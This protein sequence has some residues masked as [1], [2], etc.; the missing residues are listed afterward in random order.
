MPLRPY[1]QEQIFLLP[2]SLSEW[3][4]Q[5]H[6]ARVFSEI[7]DRID[8]HPFR[9][10]KEEGRP[11]YHPKMMLKVLLWG[12]ATGVRSSRKV[13]EKLQQDVVFMWL[14]G[15]EKPD[16]REAANRGHT[17]I[18]LGPEVRK[19]ILVMN[20]LTYYRRPGIER[21]GASTR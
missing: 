1:N 5:D 21:N 10:P 6:P 16:F 14:A 3:V 12:Y 9:E 11:A 17:H 4:R 8:T 18:L 7:I 2:P 19:I 13:E 15:L 20:D